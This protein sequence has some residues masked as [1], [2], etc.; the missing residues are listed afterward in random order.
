MQMTTP[1]NW[2]LNNQMGLGLGRCRHWSVVTKRRENHSR[3]ETAE[4]H[5]HLRCLP[6]VVC[7]DWG[8][9][10]LSCPLWRLVAA[11]CTS[12]GGS[13]SRTGER[14]AWTEGPCTRKSPTVPGTES[15]YIRKF[16]WAV[17]ASCACPAVQVKPCLQWP[18]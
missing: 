13:R 14:A 15:L 1:L 7:R 10:W 8:S 12:G 4:R 2:I 3:K 16:R 9:P 18:L 11:L 6:L 5:N 17:T